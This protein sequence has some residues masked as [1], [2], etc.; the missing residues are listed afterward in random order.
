MHL[1]RAKR[2]IYEIVPQKKL[3]TASYLW[4]NK[5]TGRFP[6]LFCA[7]KS[8]SSLSASASAHTARAS[9]TA[10]ATTG[11]SA[12]TETAGGAS[13]ATKATGTAGGATGCANGASGGSYS[14][15]GRGYRSGGRACCGTINGRACVSPGSGRGTVNRTGSTR[16]ALA[17][18]VG[19][20]DGDYKNDHEDR[21]N[22]TDTGKAGRTARGRIPSVIFIRN[23]SSSP[24]NMG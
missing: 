6:V 12:T 13:A 10:K 17:H 20:N 19:R 24:P 2:D 8:N 18:R 15:S 21:Q 16:A 9:S 23:I 5:E 11:A 1:D 14:R 3:I 7:F 4:K 22:Q